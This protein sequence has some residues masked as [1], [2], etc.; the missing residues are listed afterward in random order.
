[1]RME[2]AAWHLRLIK[3]GS[4]DMF[5]PIG[6]ATQFEARREGKKE[7]AGARLGVGV[8]APAFVT[9]ITSKDAVAERAGYTSLACTDQK[10]SACFYSLFVLF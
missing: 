4:P 3:Q 7:V 1:M 10:V 8:K 5:Y 6:I 9:G 2:R